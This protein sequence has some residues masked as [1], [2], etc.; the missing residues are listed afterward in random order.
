MRNRI[1]IA[2]RLGVGRNRNSRE[3]VKNS[4]NIWLFELKQYEVKRHYHE[5]R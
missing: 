4:F 3:K 1:D 2:G 5:N